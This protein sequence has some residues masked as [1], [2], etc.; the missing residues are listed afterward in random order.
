MKFEDFNRFAR[1]AQKS[2]Y[3]NLKKVRR[4]KQVNITPNFRLPQTKVKIDIK[5]SVLLMY[6]RTL[7]IIKYMHPMASKTTCMFENLN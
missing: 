1:F 3:A 2:P 6:S 7:P 5:I 4:D